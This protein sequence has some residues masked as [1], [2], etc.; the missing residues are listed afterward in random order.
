NLQDAGFETGFTSMYWTY[1]C[2]SEDTEVYTKDGWKQIKHLHKSNKDSI[3]IYNEKEKKYK[4]ESPSTWNSYSIKEDM[5][6]IKSKD[7]DQLVSRN[8]RVYTKQGFRYAENL[9]E[10]EEVV[11]LSNLPTDICDIF[12][13]NTQ[14][15][16]DSRNVLCNELQ[17][18]SDY[19]ENYSSQQGTQYRWAKLDRRTKRKTKESN[20]RQKELG[21]ERWSNLQ[22]TKRKLCKPIYQIYKVSKK[23]FIYGKKRWLHNRT[24]IIGSLV[25]RQ[26]IDKNGNSSS[27]RPQCREQRTKEFH[28]IQE[29]S[30][31]QEIRSRTEYKTTLATVTKEHYEGTIACP[32]ISTGCFV[33]R[34]NGKIFLTGNSGFPKAGN[35]SKMMDKRLGAEREVVGEY[36]YPDGSKRKV[37]KSGSDKYAPLQGSYGLTVPA[38]S[39]AKALDGSYLG[40]Q[41]KPAVEIIIV[42]MKPL[43]EKSYIDQAI[44]NGK[45]ISWFDDCRIPGKQGD[46]CWGKLTEAKDRAPFKS[47]VGKRE[48][49]V[50]NSQGRFP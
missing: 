49:Q 1:A 33:A 50:V 17:T 36:E 42:C 29:Q 4:F 11:Y 31:P 13:R 44:K 45:G 40:F 3:L 26:T 7:T 35:V 14:K 18:K 21:L 15:T 5:F 43:S 34:R 22:E 28:A 12:S 46:G 23:V 9:E 20:D 37:R 32:T 2:L 19:S 41:P 6:R 24:S 16:K 48:E 38:T 30:R 25:D 39:Q 8:H 27:Y 10:Q 47:G